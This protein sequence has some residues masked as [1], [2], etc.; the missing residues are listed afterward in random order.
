MQ[1]S[2]PRQPIK[3]LDLKLMCGLAGFLTSSSQRREDAMRHAIAAMTATLVH[4]GPDASGLYVDADAG[5]ALGHRRLSILDLSA[6]GAQ[7]MHSASGRFVISY[8]GE[9]YNHTEL[10]S[11]LPEQVFRGHSDTEVLL[12]AIEAWGLDQALSRSNGMFAFALWDRQERNLH[13][14]RDRLGKKPLYYGWCG[15]TLL[16]GSELSALRAYRGFNPEID[17]NALATF[18]RH[19]YVPA[20]L[21]IFKDCYKLRAG[22]VLTLNPRDVAAGSSHDPLSAQ[23][24][25]W[26]ARVQMR[27]AL[28]NP[29]TGDAPSMVEELDRLLRDAVRLRMRSDVPLGAF[30]SGGTDSSSVVALMQAQSMRRVQTF[31]IGFEEDH[32]DETDDAQA[33]AQILGTEHTQ[34]YVSGEDALAVV[35]KLPQIFSEPF[36][37]SSQIPFY[38]LAALARRHVTVALSGDGGDELFYGYSRYQRALSVFRWRRWLPRLVGTAL[39]R[40]VDTAGEQEVTNDKRIRAADELRATSLSQ[41]YLNRV[42]R[43]RRPA[44]VVLGASQRWNAFSTIPSLGSND[45]QELMYLDTLTYLPEDILTKVDRATMAVSLEARAP[46][47]DYQLV[48]YAWRVPFEFKYREGHQKWLLKQL[49]RRYLPAALIERP[50]KGF[51]APIGS[52]LRGPLRGWAEAALDPQRLRREGYFD[53][54]IVGALWQSYLQGRTRLHKR[55]WSTLM[56]QAWLEA[57]TGVASK[58]AEKSAIV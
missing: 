50:K 36:A 4:R 45:P 37:D 3:T 12:A 5:I 21:C 24:K 42:S 46:L 15:D 28:A 51:G 33:V 7:P 49:L 48:E 22:T 31:T 9:I 6:E 19:D 17:R 20:P 35:P 53:A 27:T 44:S 32:L 10:R 47:L 58:T 2:A 39:A 41:V 34:L 54:S 52:W 40:I 26:D 43:W 23:R 29:L 11:Q 14:V 8:N 55:L 56:F 25:Y 16:F 18:L 1:G 13:L 30:L 57:G 38:L